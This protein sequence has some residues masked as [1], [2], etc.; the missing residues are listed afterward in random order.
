MNVP[1]WPSSTARASS[2]AATYANGSM[3]R[4]PSRRG[5]RRDDVG[6][7]AAPAEVAAHR[8]ADLVVGLRAALAEHRDRA[9]DLPRR[10]VAALEAVV[11]DERLLHRVQRLARR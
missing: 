2:P 11:R 8:L 4:S 5:D 3:S 7:G 9:H 6:I 1:R 10:A